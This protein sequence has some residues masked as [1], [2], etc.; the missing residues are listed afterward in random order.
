VSSKSEVTRGLPRFQEL[1][2]T[3]KNVK[4]PYLTIYLKPE[5]ATNKEKASKIINE[6]AIINI[7]Q[8]ASSSKIFFDPIGSTASQG[9]LH[10]EVY[11]IFNEIACLTEDDSVANKKQLNPWV[12]MI[13]FDRKKMVEKNIKMN[14]IYYAITSKF[15]TRNGKE[16]DISCVYSDDNSSKLV[17]RIR[18]INSL[19]DTKSIAQEEDTICI[20]R[21]VERTILNDIVLTGIKGL[22][23]ASMSKKDDI[24]RFSTE[25][26]NFE[27][28]PEWVIDTSGSNLLSI[29]KHPAVDCSR[30]ISNDIHEVYAVLGI[31]AARQVLIN[32]I[33]DIFE[34]ASSDVNSRHVALLADVI[35]NKG[36]LMPMNRHG[37]N[38]SDIGP[39]AKCSFEETPD[40][41]T[42]AAIFGELDLVQGVT[43]N[44]MLGQEVPIGT[45]S[46]ELLFDEEKYIECLSDMHDEYD[47]LNTIMEEF[48]EDDA[49]NREFLD[50]VCA[51]DMFT[52]NTFDDI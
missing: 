19:I 44:I 4:S 16:D 31:E 15:N 33:N 2:S 3:T 17:M 25:T 24:Y 36:G 40:V 9:S 32:E 37:I 5:Y 51:N 49:E 13:E 11:D 29:F 41:I 47:G 35:T 21:T 18:C 46:V 42:R 38:K 22:T 30:T 45:G 39:L 23:N 6:I 28:Q 10:E 20:L 1:L 34:S 26:N 27:Q 50:T 48:E 7:K 14:D 8:L 12:L 43:S 52:D